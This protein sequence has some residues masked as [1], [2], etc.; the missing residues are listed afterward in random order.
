VDKKLMFN[1]NRPQLPTI[2]T[3][4]IEYKLGRPQR[5]FGIGGGIIPPIGP[6]ALVQTATLTALVQTATLTA[7]VQTEIP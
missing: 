5:P 4:E 2:L 6:T 1:L 7:L 3:V